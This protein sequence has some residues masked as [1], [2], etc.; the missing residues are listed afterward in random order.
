M[1]VALLLLAAIVA[2]LVW[3]ANRSAFFPSRYP[4]GDWDS[5]R[6]LGAVEL[7]FASLDGTPLSAWWLEA[8]E[9]RTATLFLH[10]NAGNASHRTPSMEEIAAAGSSVLVLD[11]RGYGK[12]GGRATEA[13]LYKD[14]H[15]ALTVLR[16]KVSLPVVLHGESLGTAVATELANDAGAAGLVLESPFPSARAVAARVLPGLGPLLVW[17][18]NT[19]ARIRTV[20]CPILILHGDLD[21]VIDI[22]LGR[23]VFDAAPEPKEFWL[24]PGAGHNNL[25]ATA[26]PQYRARLRAFYRSLAP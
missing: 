15:A 6:R 16:A 11:Y 5:L 2:F 21:E 20:R 24:I 10:G 19:E 26:G 23:R 9:A 22:S 12:S 18:F 13:G 17:G 3:G 7:N 8:K 4:H 14:A 25:A 1:V